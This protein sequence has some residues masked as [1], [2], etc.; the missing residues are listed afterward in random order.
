MSWLVFPFEMHS[1]AK[2]VPTA[3]GSR[4]CGNLGQLFAGFFPGARRVRHR[5]ITV[6]TQGMTPA[7]TLGGQPT[8]FDCTMFFKSFHGI[9]RAGGLKAARRGD[10]RRQADLI[11]P[12]YAESKRKRQLADKPADPNCCCSQDTHDRFRF[13]SFFGSAPRGRRGWCTIWRARPKSS[14]KDCHGRS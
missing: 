10:E 8:A 14:S 4:A 13:P 7:N 1:T 9:G 6:S 12:H 3:S 2:I 5:I 11:E